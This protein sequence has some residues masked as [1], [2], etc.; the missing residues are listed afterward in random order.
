MFDQ[1]KS[2]KLEIIE[3]YPLLSEKIPSNLSEKGTCH[4]RI[5]N[6]DIEI[7]NIP[8]FISHKKEKITIRL[9]GSVYLS[10]GSKT[11]LPSIRFPHKKQWTD[12]RKQLVNEI[13]NL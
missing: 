4:I 8:Y 12:I 9:P 5:E 7:A 13:K 2:L 1:E 6:W 3:I 10:N 11:F